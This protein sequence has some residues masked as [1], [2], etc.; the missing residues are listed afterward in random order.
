MA[1]LDTFRCASC[2]AEFVIEPDA[3]RPACPL[4]GAELK[5]PAQSETRPQ[6]QEARGKGMAGS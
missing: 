5:R 4:C 6:P 3:S 1:N 2:G